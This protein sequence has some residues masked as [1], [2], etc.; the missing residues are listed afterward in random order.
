MARDL[1]LSSDEGFGSGCLLVSG[2]VRLER[3]DAA[4]SEWITGENQKMNGHGRAWEA[5]VKKTEKEKTGRDRW[6]HIYHVCASTSWSLGKWEDPPD[7]PPKRHGR[8]QN[9]DS[10]PA[11]V[12]PER[13]REIQA[14]ICAKYAARSAPSAS[15]C[16]A[17]HGGVRCSLRSDDARL[18]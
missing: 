7:W 15:L 4:N 5:P 1:S 14:W 16:I 8:P 3:K 10:S 9:D 18:L 2:I 13:H 12:R 6:R 11:L 17:L